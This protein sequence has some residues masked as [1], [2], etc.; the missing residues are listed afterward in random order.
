[1]ARTIYMYIEVTD[2]IAS[3]SAW[4][5]HVKRVF[6]GFACNTNKI[7]IIINAIHVDLLFLLFLLNN[8]N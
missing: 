3:P 5:W 4:V 8:G 2:N 7:I 1:M 6:C